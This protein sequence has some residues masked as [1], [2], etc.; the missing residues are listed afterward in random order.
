MNKLVP[1]SLISTNSLQIGLSAVTVFLCVNAAL[2]WFQPSSV[3]NG[4]IAVWPLR[5]LNNFK[6]PHKFDTSIQLQPYTALICC[7][8][9]RSH[10]EAF[11]LFLFCENGE[12]H[13]NA[14]D[15][16]LSIWRMEIS[17]LRRRHFS[18][19]LMSSHVRFHVNFCSE[20][21]RGFCGFCFPKRNFNI[22]S[23]FQR[24]EQRRY[25]CALPRNMST[26]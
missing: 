26:L 19:S 15:V 10:F 20:Y 3:A 13:S 5:H 23:E 11:E 24:V 9:S 8:K 14:I 6:R 16:D 18:L 2:H 7:S 1:V 25:D 21:R 22:H 17:L 4:E 12:R